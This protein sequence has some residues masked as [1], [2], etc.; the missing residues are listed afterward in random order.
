[1]IAGQVPD[2]ARKLVGN[3]TIIKTQ[4]VYLNLNQI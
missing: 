3:N 2:I 1:M 4:G